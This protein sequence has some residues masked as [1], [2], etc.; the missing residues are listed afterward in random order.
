MLLNIILKPFYKTAGKFDSWPRMIF[1][2]GKTFPVFIWPSLVIYS[3]QSQIL[4]PHLLRLFHALPN[5]QIWQILFDPFFGCPSII[6]VGYVVID[7][8]TAPARLLMVIQKQFLP[9]HFI[10]LKYSFDQESTTIFFAQIPSN[11]IIFFK[12]IFEH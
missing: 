8:T 2:V 3:S 10:R 7:Q 4:A 9:K 11:P 1:E 6:I 12:V 5:N